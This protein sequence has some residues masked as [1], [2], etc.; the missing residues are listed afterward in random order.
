MLSEWFLGRRHTAGRSMEE[1]FLH[2]L[3]LQKLQVILPADFH[4]EP[5]I[6]AHTPDL[7]VLVTERSSLSSQK[8][9]LTTSTRKFCTGDPEETG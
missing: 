8:L 9:Q 4:R 5:C 1:V 6:V 2:V 7:E 3:T